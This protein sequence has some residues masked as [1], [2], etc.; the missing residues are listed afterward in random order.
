MYNVEELNYELPALPYN[1]DALEPYMDGETM[2]IHHGK[3]HK[4]Y[5]DKFREVSEKNQLGSNPFTL[6]KD[7]STV[8]KDALKGIKNFGGGHYNHAF[9]W[10][11][12]RKDVKPSISLDVIKAI[13]KKFGNLDKFVE[14]FTTA[15]S[16]FF[17][18]GWTWLVVNS[19]GE[20]EITNSANQDSPISNKEQPVLCL[21]LWEHAYY[22]KYR[23]MRA[24]YIKAFFN[25]IN[26]E[27]VNEYYNK[28]VKR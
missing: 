23:N 24:D 19:Q 10:T 6:L 1:Y 14:Q 4:T 25:I 22:L 21:D 13:N 18:S 16:T 9:F 11:I 5:A 15:S 17:G 20:L 7:L 27:K 28:A 26:W 12:L 2:K 8:P 3:H